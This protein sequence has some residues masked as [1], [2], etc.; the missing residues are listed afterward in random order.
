MIIKT[1]KILDFV[2]PPLRG[3]ASNSKHTEKHCEDSEA[4]DVTVTKREYVCNAGGQG[5]SEEE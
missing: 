1:G 5:V 3:E 4:G 2:D